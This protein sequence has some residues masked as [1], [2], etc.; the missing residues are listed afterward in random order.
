M[1]PCAQNVPIQVKNI[2]P[3]NTDSFH[4]KTIVIDK[5]I[6]ILGSTNWTAS[7]FDN[8]IET[9]VLINSDKLAQEILSY[10]KTI[11]IDYAAEKYL[12]SIG[13]VTPISWEFLE[14]Q[15]IAALMGYNLKDKRI[16]GEGSEKGV[17]RNQP[18][19]YR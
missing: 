18:E 11:K 10:L 13:P 6:V 5:K 17:W 8:N 14:N 19:E 2:V 7:A 12:E 15:K 9:D 16:R 4:L 1:H 3:D